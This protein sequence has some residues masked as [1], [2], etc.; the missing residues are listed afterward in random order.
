MIPS[1]DWREKLS[2]VDGAVC[3]QWGPEK[4][5]VDGREVSR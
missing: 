4:F 5:F 3:G 2:N 1:R